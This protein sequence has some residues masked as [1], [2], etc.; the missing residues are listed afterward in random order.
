MSETISK[1]VEFII[2]ETKMKEFECDD[3]AINEYMK[4]NKL[5]P[6]S[7]Q[8]VIVFDLHNVLDVINNTTSLGTNDEMLVVCCSFIGYKNEELKSK[9]R[10]DILARI[11]S[12]QINYGILVF[13]R[14]K[15]KKR[16]VKT[17]NKIGSKA[18]FC[19]LVNCNIFFD[20]GVDHIESVKEFTSS[21]AFLIKR[22]IKEEELVEFIKNK[23]KTLTGGK[24][25]YIK[26]LKYKM[27]YLALKNLLKY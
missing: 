3:K 13:K 11:Y 25:F 22:G 5:F 9:A 23:I 16:T 15:R 6:S 27:K 8:K 19:G 21:D 18:W 2:S 10:K 4:E 12:G 1:C 26:Y 14:G 17:T 7:K 24:S 20:D